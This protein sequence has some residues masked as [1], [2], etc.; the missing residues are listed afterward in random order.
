MEQNKTPSQE[1]IQ[2]QILFELAEIKKSILEYAGIGSWLTRRQVMKF[3]CY[4][5]TAMSEL[6]KSGTIEFSQVGRRK[7]FRKEAIIALLEKNIKIN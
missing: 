2:R 6:E 3:L 5:D 4:Q 1:G 7:F